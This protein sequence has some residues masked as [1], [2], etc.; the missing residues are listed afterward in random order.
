MKGQMDMGDTGD[1]VV[2]CSGQHR[3]ARR[4]NDVVAVAE[5]AREGRSRRLGL[6][7]LQCLQPGTAGPHL[8][9]VLAERQVR[10]RRASVRCCDRH[11]G[12]YARRVGWVAKPRAHGK[13]T[14]AVRD[15]DWHNAGGAGDALHSLVDERGIAFNGAENGLE[16]D[17][18]VRHAGI[19][20]SV[21][22]WIP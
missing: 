8:P 5:I 12:M 9:R 13:A 7:S 10:Q 19:A 21:H 14:H 6:D 17:R 16:V 15:D 3:V 2:R 20:Q 11:H 18:R 22:P 1:V 4:E